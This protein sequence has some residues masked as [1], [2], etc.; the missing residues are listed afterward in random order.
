VAVA[1]GFALPLDVVDAGAHLY[2]DL[3][4]VQYHADQPHG[5]ASFLPMLALARRARDHVKVV[6]TGEGADEI[7]GG[8]AWSAGAPYNTREPWP[9]VRERVEANAVFTAEEKREILA[10]PL[11]PRDSAE[12]VRAILADAPELDPLSE[13][14]YVDLALLLPGNNLVKADRMGMACG[15]EL[16]CPVLDHRIVEHAFAL[17]ADLKRDKR[18]LRDALRTELPDGV[19]DRPKRLFAV[20]V[21]EWLRGPASGLLDDLADHPSPPLDGWLR[22]D[23]V[24]RLV[25]EH[26]DGMDRT[27]KLRALVALNAWASSG[28]LG[29]DGESRPA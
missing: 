26:R 1:R 27:R 21:G 2:D 28:L 9:A 13:T 6:L 20:P 24:A 15:V 8:Y 10:E 4:V 14:L 11:S 25:R 22:R 12:R 3:R 29:T 18:A 19:A 16:R 17:A 5:D 23:A 7:F